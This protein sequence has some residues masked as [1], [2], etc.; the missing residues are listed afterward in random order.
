[1]SKLIY[2]GIDLHGHINVSLGL[3]RALVEK[4]EEVLYYSSDVF[5]EKIEATGAQF[6]NYGDMGG[7]EMREGIASIRSSYSPITFWIKATNL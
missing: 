1:M 5:R 2:F 6:R 4:G 7:F 3:I